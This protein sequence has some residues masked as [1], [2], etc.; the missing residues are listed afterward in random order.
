MAAGR[1]VVEVAD[2]AVRRLRSVAFRRDRE[3]SW[4]RL[5]RL[6]GRIERDGIDSLG[7]SE[8]VELPTLHRAAVSSLSVARAISLD[9]SLLEYL[10]ALTARSH[11]CVHATPS[12][13]WRAFVAF[14][15]AGFAAAVRRS[16][17]PVLVALATV[18]LG[19]A[20]GFVAV[21]QDLANYDLLVDPGMAQG[22][23]ASA[24]VESLRAGLYARDA[25][26]VDGL[27][28]FASFLFQ[29]NAQ[30]GILCF[31]L[32]FAAGVPTLLLLLFNGTLLGAMAALFHLRGLGVDFWGWVLPHGVTE[33]LAIVLCGGA[34]LLQGRAVLMPGQRTRAG[35]LRA[36][37]GDAA[38]IVLGCVGMLAVAALLEGFFR[39]LVHEVAVRYAVAAATAAFWGCYFLWPRRTAGEGAA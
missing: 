28:R 8:L 4:Q 3:A 23:D 37:G 11:F 26:A 27:T 31:A 34:G 5:E 21:V 16:A 14:W 10:E 32:G 22:R 13:P 9:R 20:I 35:A 25:S 1:A 36:V 15:T 18:V 24:S 33:L 29:N 39:Q 2:G 12:D 19:V 30:V 6:V 17:G 38:R 7:E